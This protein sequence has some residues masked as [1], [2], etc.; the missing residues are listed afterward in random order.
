[1]TTPR[2]EVSILVV[3]YNTRAM[4]LACLES[5][6]RETKRHDY[7]IVVVDNA[8]SDGS[9]DEIRDR[10]DR[11]TLIE[12]GRNLGFAAANN[13]AAEHAR[14][15][16][17][18]LLNPDTVVLD[19]ALDTLVDAAER[20]GEGIYGGRTVFEGGSLNPSSC[21]GWM[22]PWSLLCRAS[23]LSLAAPGSES[24]NPETY[25][26]WRRDTVRPVDV[27]SGCLFLLPA[28][29]W[30]RL[31]GFDP[32]FF[33]FGEEVDLCRRASRQGIPRVLIPDATIIHH[34]GASEPVRGKSMTL[35]F[36]AKVSEIRRHWRRGSRHLGVA[37]LLAWA[38]TRA[39]A[40]GVLARADRR[41]FAEPAA[42]WTHVWNARRA[43]CRGFPPAPEGHGAVRL[44]EAGA[45]G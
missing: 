42:A 17:L 43:W 7:E 18:L 10:F 9:A 6:V 40:Y 44:D 24:L 38:G 33:M 1:M 35:I 25:G 11:V 45:A 16:W 5:I 26:G 12:P 19:G 34:G 41:R 13:L 15:R 32:S 31:E 21:H 36:T 28:D 3:S 39:A 29:L 2:P 8:S 37:L 20:R 14:G 4:T 30:N 27:V 23:G 22:T